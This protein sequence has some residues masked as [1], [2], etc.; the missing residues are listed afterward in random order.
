MVGEL[1]Q[2][3]G[4]ARPQRFDAHSAQIWVGPLGVL[5]VLADEGPHAQ[6]ELGEKLRIDRSTVVSIVYGLEETGRVERRRDREDRRRYELTLTETGRLALSEVEGG[7]RG[8]Q[9]AVSKSLDDLG[10]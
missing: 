10:H 2:R 8:V 5:A 7:V 3:P 9:E 6:R 4:K 1:W